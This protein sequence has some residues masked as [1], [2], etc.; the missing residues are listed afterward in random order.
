MGKI[1]T[2]ILGFED[3]EESQKKKQKEK[4]QFKKSEKQ[5][6]E[7]HPKAQDES[8][9]KVVTTSENIEQA[10]DTTAKSD[11]SEEKEAK[12]TKKSKKQAKKRVRGKK[13]NQAK[14]KIDTSKKYTLSEG[15]E[16]IKKLSYTSFD[17]SIEL[18]LVLNK[19]G[20]KGEI[21]LPHSTGKTVKV[22]IVDTALFDQLEKGTIDFDILVTTPQNMPQLAK[23]AKLLGPRGLMPNAKSG[24][25]SDKPEELVKK[26]SSGLLAWKSEPKFPLIHQMIG[27]VSLEP[28]KLSANSKA[29]IQ[30]VGA[31]HIEAAYLASSMSPS[32]A[33]DIASL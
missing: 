2:R 4:A 27:K 19:K 28:D 7:E 21:Q 22:R 9:E 12:S 8:K 33:I 17:E 26:F 32:V 25:I 10:I 31:K 29:F 5:K 11:K 14:L 16:L 15:L 13:Y 6:G 30:S 23:F 1:R 3:V 24:T 18:H 20:L